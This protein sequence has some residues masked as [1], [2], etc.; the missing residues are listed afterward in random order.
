LVRNLAHGYFLLA[1]SF[2]TGS[3]AKS[4]LA[5]AQPCLSDSLVIRLTSAG[6]APVAFRPLLDK[7]L[8]Y[9]TRN[10]FLTHSSSSSTTTHPTLLG[11]QKHVAIPSRLSSS[12]GG[13]HATTMLPNLLR[14]IPDTPSSPSAEDIFSSALSTL[15]PDDLQ[16]QH[17]D[18]DTRIVYRSAAHGDLELRCADVA[19]EE[20]LT[21]F[22]H[23]LWN[24][25]VLMAEIV[26]G[27]GS[28]EK[29]GDGTEGDEWGKR[30]F[31]GGRS[32]WIEGREEETW[33]VKGH[34]VL[35][36]GAGV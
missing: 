15:F 19:G 11:A 5:S 9:P 10:I 29:D 16:V 24:A 21:K 17:G 23:Y 12:Q 4:D 28:Q 35:E 33:A 18:P 27:R 20:D 36:L 31:R 22:A 25:G 13:Y 32:W 30:E 2:V 14:L 8:L 3:L 6:C 26:G 34:K 1:V 7:H